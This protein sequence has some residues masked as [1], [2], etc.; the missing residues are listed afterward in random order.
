M[1]GVMANKLSV[2]TTDN[3]AQYI[4]GVHWLTDNAGAGKV[5]KNPPSSPFQSNLQWWA[6]GHLS[7][8]TFWIKDPKLALLFRMVLPTCNTIQ[9]G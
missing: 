4:Y 5:W 8:Y 6:D 9:H 2:L 7:M 3:P 1:G